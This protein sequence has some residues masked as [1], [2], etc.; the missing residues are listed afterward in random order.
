VHVTGN[1]V[2]A[3]R[4]VRPDRQGLEYSESRLGITPMATA[5]ST[6]Q[7]ILQKLEAQEDYERALS[8]TITEVKAI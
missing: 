8:R 2:R 3:V 4:N 6:C 5:P 1:L 7:Q